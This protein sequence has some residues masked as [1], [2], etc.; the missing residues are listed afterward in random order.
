MPDDL[1][2]GEINVVE[3]TV[4]AEDGSIRTYTLNVTRLTNN[5]ETDL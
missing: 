5:S 3:I 2:V 4:T 1:K